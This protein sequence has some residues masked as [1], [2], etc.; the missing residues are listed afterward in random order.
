MVSPRIDRLSVFM[1]PCTKPTRIHSAIRRA[2]RSQTSRN[3]SARSCSRLPERC[4]KSRAIVKSMSR[5]SSATSSREA[6]S[7]KLPK[8]MNEGATRQTI[9]P[10]SARG[11]PS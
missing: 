8:R 5:S 4:G 11:R 7:S 3:Q 1:T 10:G 2:V 6:G 9:A